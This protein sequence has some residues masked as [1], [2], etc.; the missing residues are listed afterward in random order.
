MQRKGTQLAANASGMIFAYGGTSAPD[1]Y[2]LCYG[3]EY[4]VADYPTLASILGSNFGSPSDVDHFK[5]PDLRGR[6]TFGFDNMGSV[7]ASRIASG[8]KIS[9]TNGA[10]ET[11]FLTVNYVIKT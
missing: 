8:D 7:A 6:T 1:G 10:G 9:T 4:L 11:H 5:V 3:Q 2:L